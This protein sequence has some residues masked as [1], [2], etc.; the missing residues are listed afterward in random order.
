MLKVRLL[1]VQYHVLPAR[2]GGR[3]VITGL[4]LDLRAERSVVNGTGRRASLS[5]PVILDTKQ[6]HPSKS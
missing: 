2:S 5:I 4:A 3:A 6:K 1:P